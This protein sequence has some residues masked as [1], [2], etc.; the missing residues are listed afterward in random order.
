MQDLY[1]PYLEEWLALGRQRRA[2]RGDRDEEWA[3]FRG[4]VVAER[5]QS[6]SSLLADPCQAILKAAVTNKSEG[7][8]RL[9]VLCR[10]V[11]SFQQG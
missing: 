8:W 9:K 1:Q 10:G 6:S 5:L 3:E 2:P 7:H 11:E 4:V